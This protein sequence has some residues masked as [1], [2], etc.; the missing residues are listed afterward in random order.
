M[1]LCMIIGVVFLT[2][3][4]VMKKYI[5]VRN[6]SIILALAIIT[7]I[8]YNGCRNNNPVEPSIKAD[9]GQLK[10][11]DNF[12]FSTTKELSVHL[13]IM[14]SNTNEPTHKFGIYQG[15][16]DQGGKLI[17]SGITD[18]YKTFQTTIKIPTYV[19]E[20]YIT[21]QD[22]NNNIETV[23]VDAAGNSIYY[24]FNTQTYTANEFKST[25]VLYTD[26]G[27]GTCD[28]IIASGTY[29]QKDIDNNTIYCIE[30]GSTV[31]FTQ[32]IEFK[33]GTLIV[34]GNLDLKEVKANNNGGDFVISSGGVLDLDDGDIDKD[35]TNFINFGTTNID[36]QT[37]IR[38][39]NFENQGT[40][41]VDGGVNNR[42]INF[43]ND[44]TMTVNGNFTNNDEGFNTGT[45]NINGHFINNGSPGTE[46]TNE[47]K[48][49]ISGNFNLS[50]IFNNEDNAY[51]EVGQTATLTGN[52]N[53][54]ILN[55]GVQ[56]LISTTNLT[57][58]TTIN[59][60][61]VS[62]ARIDISETTNINGSGIITGLMDIC[63]A[64]GIENDNGTIGPDVTFDC[65][66]F[67]ATT[68]CNPG[69]GTPP[70]PDTDGDGC[71]DDQDDYP[72]DAD[73]C[74]NDYYPNQTDFTNLAC[75]D[76]WTSLGD[77]DFNDLIL[78]TN[79]KIVKDAQ[80]EIVEI[81]GKFHIAAV[82]A[83]LNNG[84]GIE[85]DIPTSAVEIVTGAEIDGSAVTMK[86]NGIE[87]GPLNNAVMIVFSAIND[88]LGTA[89]VNTIPGGNSM[90]I[91]TITVYMKFNVPQ[92]SIGT[93]P[94]NPFMFI[95]QTRGKEIHKID[96]A[97]TELVDDSY[98]GEKADDSNPS[99]GRY[100]V[101]ET[102][103]PWVIEIPQQFNWP[104]EKAD[105]LTAYLKFQLWAES[106]GV[107]F[108]DWY[109]DQPGYRNTSNIYQTP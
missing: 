24:S 53:T 28:E 54:T 106:S 97:P 41:T 19:N 94:Y 109:E 20:L 48:M 21:N 58:N 56:S 96:H 39:M 95:N 29:N 75:E 72:N 98:F 35:L 93:P 31:T 40:L 76:L 17:L 105:I 91:D 104:N 52:S 66:C 101:S 6:N 51:V 60:P 62:C 63:D 108:T 82:G 38:D 85:F 64:D 46:F 32:E 12:K 45:L 9:F 87:D 33:G 102:N 7:I 69:A 71:P 23:V 77:Y 61:S 50:R 59:G 36:G 84:F 34:C 81:Y 13:E 15:N 10:I 8:G 88:Y 16:P 1:Y 99:I 92:A 90:V 80:N 65:S 47:C 83:S 86:P 79:Y 103:L 107:Q 78:E 73:R 11:S 30:A 74:S 68:S 14:S 4:I 5:K 22:V 57:V 49:I 67:V 37:E 25:N 100:Y 2:K 55:M 89:M 26:P 43:Y 27:C 3:T 18:P 44:G 42:T 70:N